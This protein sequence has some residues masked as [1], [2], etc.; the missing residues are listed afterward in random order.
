V[1]LVVDFWGKIFRPVA[2]VRSKRDTSQG[3]SAN[4]GKYEVAMAFLSG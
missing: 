2:E 4:F 3:V 1:D